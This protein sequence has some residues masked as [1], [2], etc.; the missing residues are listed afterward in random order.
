MAAIIIYLSLSWSKDGD[1]KYM[2]TLFRTVTCHFSTSTV[3][4]RGKEVGAIP[5]WWRL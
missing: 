1:I 4:S 5:L 3:I 2:A